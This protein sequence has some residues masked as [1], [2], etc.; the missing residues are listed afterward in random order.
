MP[1]S[2]E[3]S[4]LADLRHL[5]QFLAVA[6]ERS[7]TR[8]AK[9]LGMAQPP[10]SQAIRKLED[11]LESHLFVRT[12]RAVN[13]T[14]SGRV[15]FQQARSLLEQ[16]ER[17]IRSVRQ[18]AEGSVG[19]LEVCF[20]M[21][22]GYELLPRALRQFRIDLPGVSI[23]LNE[24]STAQ[25]VEALQSG[26]CDVGLLC[27]PIFG[28]SDL[29]VETVL[30]EPIVV[31]LPEDHRLASEKKVALAD[32]ADEAFISPPA[33]LGPGL[34]AR[35]LDICLASGF[36][37]KIEQ[38]AN[39]MQTIVSLVAG[40]LG[41]ALVPKAVASLGLEGMVFRPLSAMKP[42]PTVEIALAWQRVEAQRRPYIQAFMEVVKEVSIHRQVT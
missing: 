41:I 29:T 14:E 8:A 16:H 13:L 12:S 19:H 5:R 22:S 2:Y 37:P 35:I 25:Q 32:L 31:A 10:L 42:I 21:S 17:A 18:A 15:L 39:Q 38:E 30:S 23:S 7:F 4:I 9:K 28:G 33:R 3:K 6:E 11:N 27:P 26:R 1:I 20:V 40:G 34:Y 24:L 36:V